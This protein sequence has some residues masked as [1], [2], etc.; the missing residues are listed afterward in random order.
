MP[1]VGL[2]PANEH[3]QTYALDRAELLKNWTATINSL[4]EHSHLPR[5][6]A[7]SLGNGR[8][9]QEFFFDISTLKN[10]HTA[11]PRKVGIRV[12]TG[13]AS[14]PRQAESSATSLRKPQNNVIFL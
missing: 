14:F 11:W 7:A 2:E 13:G 5:Y 9:N 1:L 6:D 4:I 8:N 12:P 10:E 3:R